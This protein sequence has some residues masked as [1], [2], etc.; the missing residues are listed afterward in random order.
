MGEDTP[1]KDP[2]VQ[3]YTFHPIGDGDTQAYAGNVCQ[4]TGRVTEDVSLMEQGP[5]FRI[6]FGDGHTEIATAAE[7][8]PWFP[9]D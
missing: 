8:R 3:G 4:I 1:Q 7:L 9:T 2:Y 6:V 5:M